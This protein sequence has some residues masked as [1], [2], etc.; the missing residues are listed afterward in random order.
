MNQRSLAFSPI[1]LWRQIHFAT[2]ST[3][4]TAVRLSHSM[5]SSTPWICRKSVTA[6]AWFARMR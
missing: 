5:W 2:A 3:T 1:G 4:S 6:T